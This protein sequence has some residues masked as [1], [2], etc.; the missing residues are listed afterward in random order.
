[1]MKLDNNFNLLSQNAGTVKA[2]YKIITLVVGSNL[3]VAYSS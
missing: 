3:K 2:W 1:M